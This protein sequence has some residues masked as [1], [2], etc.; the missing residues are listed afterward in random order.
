MVGQKDAH[1]AET[2]SRRNNDQ[3]IESTFTESAIQRLRECRREA[4]LFQLVMIMLWLY[5]VP[6]AISR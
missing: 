4:M 3:I 1:F 5:G 6:Q 2:P